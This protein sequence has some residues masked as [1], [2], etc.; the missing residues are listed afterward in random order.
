M[1]RSTSPF[2][3]KLRSEEIVYSSCTSRR[4]RII[5]ISSLFS[6]LEIVIFPAYGLSVDVRPVW[7]I[8]AVTAK[9]FI[10]ALPP[11]ALNVSQDMSSAIVKLTISSVVLWMVK[12]CDVGKSFSGVFRKL[13]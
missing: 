13:R 4:T 12:V 2:G 11:T 8:V 6:V 10:P 3:L 1:V 5:R 9:E 7:S